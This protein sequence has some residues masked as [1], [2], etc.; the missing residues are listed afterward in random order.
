MHQT[1]SNRIKDIGSSEFCNDTDIAVD[2]KRNN[3]DNCAIHNLKCGV[4]DK[5]KYKIICNVDYDETNT[6]GV[7]ENMNL[8][9]Y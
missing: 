4:S 1:Y 2:A 6:G 7:I 8:H 3:N 9:I 5:P